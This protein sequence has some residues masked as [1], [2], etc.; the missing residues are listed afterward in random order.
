MRNLICLALAGLIS[1]VPAPEDDSF[2]GG[3]APVRDVGTIQLS[4]RGPVEEASVSDGEP[5]DA[6]DSAMADRGPET[7][8]TPTDDRVNLADVAVSVDVPLTP[9]DG[10]PPGPCGPDNVVLPLGDLP[11]DLD[12]AMQGQGRWAATCG[13]AAGGE[14]ILHY[15]LPVAADALTFTTEHPE[16]DHPAVL[17]LRTDCTGAELS[18]TRG[19]AA[20]P[21]ASIT[22][23]APSAGD[24]YLFVDT[25][26]RMGPT[27]LRV[28]AVAQLKPQCRNE[29]DDDGDGSVDGA[30]CGC[31]SL[32]D[33]DELDL[34]D[35]P[36]CCNREDDDGDG[37]SDYPNDPD[38]VTAGTDREAPLCPEGAAVLLVDAAGGRVELPELVG[39]GGA[40]AS[41]DP[42]PGPE[43]VLV[44][45]LAEA[46]HVTVT[47]QE[48]GVA[49][50]TSVYARTGCADAESE[51]ACLRSDRQ[52][53][54]RLEFVPQ[55][56]LFVFI[57]DGLVNH[58]G[59]REAIVTVESA[60]RDCNDGIDN[61]FDGSVDLLDLGCTDLRD[62]GEADPLDIPACGNGLDDDADGQIDFPGDRGCSAA[63]DAREGG[64]E[65][66]ALWQP[67]SCIAESWMWS[68]DRAFQD[69]QSANDNQVLYSGCNHSGDNAQGLCSLDGTG[70]VSTDTFVMAGCDASWWHI[71]GRHT[72]DCGGHDG[73]TVRYL[74]LGQDDCWDYR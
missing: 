55:G 51:L 53:P 9:V 38:C 49:L 36:L 72:G 18:C 8:A 44:I 1:C 3:D 69:L 61:D 37:Q 28:S 70:W 13:G 17:Y 63:G 41:C 40:T 64:C 46:S 59:P 27:T 34:P 62:D 2:G 29:I 4:D 50:N 47:V 66:H 25:G 65:G 43:H 26:A 57:E 48:N 23:R 31:D 42:L 73:D 11:L 74:A 45:P 14:F 58:L 67:V 52:G 21:G 22:L 10:P 39:V 60:V 54:L 12:L 30:D 16:T 32:E 35:F 33:D 56:Q 5:P 68:S 19:S 24:Y 71:G 6:R 7:D 20:Q 15:H